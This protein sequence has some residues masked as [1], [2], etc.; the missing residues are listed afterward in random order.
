MNDLAFLC[1]DDIFPCRA[2][3]VGR[4]VHFDVG[5]GDGDA[6][7]CFRCLDIGCGVAGAADCSLCDFGFFPVEG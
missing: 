6:L 1:R 4:L 5:N 2:A 7:A 3:L